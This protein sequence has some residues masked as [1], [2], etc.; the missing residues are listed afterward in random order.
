MKIAVAGGTGTVGTHVVRV[1]RM[2]GHEIV[3]LSRATGVDLRDGNGLSIALEGVDVVVD[4]SSTQTMSARGSVSFFRSVTENLLATEKSVGVAHHV[5]L[6]IVGIDAAP[7]AYY[8]GKAAQEK[9]VSE[10]SVPW[11]I[12]RSTQFHEFASQI[13]G[14][15]KVGPFVIVPTMRSQPVAAR[16]VAERLVDL[17]EGTPEGRTRDLGGPREERMADMVRGYASAI[18]SRVRIVELPVPGAYGRALRNGSLLTEAD[19]DRG[20]QTFADWLV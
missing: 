20:D 10:G 17:A 1:A 8:A 2:R 18:H 3:V 7:K 4:V 12:L 15:L 19:A 13:Y 6:S 11:T 14:Q 16:E 5:T 9:A